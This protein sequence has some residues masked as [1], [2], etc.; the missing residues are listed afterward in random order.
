[1][2]ADYKTDGVESE[3]EIQARAAVYAP[4][5]AMYARAVQ[6]A[7]EIAEGPRFELWFLRAGVSAR[8]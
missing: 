3:E 6:E 4:Q 7:L 5:G 1:V 8:P 2:F